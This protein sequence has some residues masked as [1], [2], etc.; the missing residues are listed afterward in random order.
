MLHALHAALWIERFQLQAALRGFDPLPR[1]T[2]AGLLDAAPAENTRDAGIRLL[3][4][5]ETAQRHGVHAG[6][7]ASQTLP[8]LYAAYPLHEPLCRTHRRRQQ[9]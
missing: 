4:V 7:T 3:H 8:V 6:L 1:Q 5:N 9:R 2:A